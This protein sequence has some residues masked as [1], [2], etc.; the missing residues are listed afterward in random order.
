[1]QAHDVEAICRAGAKKSSNLSAKVKDMDADLRKGRMPPSRIL[2]RSKSQIR[3][4]T[5]RYRKTR[6]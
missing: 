4:G 3:V 1:M 5:R 2:L 6:C